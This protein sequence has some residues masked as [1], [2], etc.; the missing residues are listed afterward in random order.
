M[1]LPSVRRAK[2][3]AT[4]VLLEGLHRLPLVQGAEEDGGGQ[5]ELAGLGRSGCLRV[6]V[7]HPV[8]STKTF[9]SW[10]AELSRV[11]FHLPRI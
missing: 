6:F 11:C 3:P 7:Y 5:R 9:R 8:D 2:R 1:F 4:G 10:E